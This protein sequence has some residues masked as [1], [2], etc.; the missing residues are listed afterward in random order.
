MIQLQN[1][2]K[3]YKTKVKD[4]VVAPGNANLEFENKGTYLDMKKEELAN[5]SVNR[6]KELPLFHF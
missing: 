4:S 6:N 2:T 1:V 3:L 5:Y